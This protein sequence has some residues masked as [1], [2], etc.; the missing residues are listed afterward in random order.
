MRY[1]L[2]HLKKQQSIQVIQI[3]SS[4]CAQHICLLEGSFITHLYVTWQFCVT[5]HMNPCEKTV[6]VNNQYTCIV[7]PHSLSP[8]Q[9][10]WSVPPGGERWLLFGIN[11]IS[12]LMPINS[13]SVGPQHNLISY[14][15]YL[16]GLLIELQ[17][18]SVG[19]HMVSVFAGSFVDADYLKLLIFTVRAVKYSINLWK[20]FCQIWCIA[21]TS[22]VLMYNCNSKRSQNPNITLKGWRSM[23]R[24]ILYMIL[25]YITA[26]VIWKTI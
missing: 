18:S 11:T 4:I 15:F 14:Y 24:V 16:Y 10:Y 26:L 25:T 1:L 17:N 5:C 22:Q 13:W 3:G 6:I 12:I 20:V 7:Q 2:Q 23:W 21:K 19:C 8:L 9:L